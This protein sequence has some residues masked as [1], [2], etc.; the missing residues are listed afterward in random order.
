MQI[1]YRKATDLFKIIKLNSFSSETIIITLYLGT[2]KH[3]I[4]LFFNSKLK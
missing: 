1:E 2:I 3:A 4:Q